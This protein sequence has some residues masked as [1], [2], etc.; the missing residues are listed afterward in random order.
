MLLVFVKNKMHE[1][2]NIRNHIWKTDVVSTIFVSKHLFADFNF[3]HDISVV[4]AIDM[5]CITNHSLIAYFQSIM[6]L[7]I[8]ILRV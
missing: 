3:E 4:F 6:I 1:N 7:Y 8:D 2:R 5:Y